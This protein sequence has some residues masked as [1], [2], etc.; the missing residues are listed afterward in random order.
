M[1]VVRILEDVCLDTR[2]S[3][4]RRFRQSSWRVSLPARTLLA[5]SLLSDNLLLGSL[6]GTNTLRR[7]TKQHV[8]KLLRR[9]TFHEHTGTASGRFVPPYLSF[10]SPGTVHVAFWSDCRTWARTL[11]ALGIHISCVLSI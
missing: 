4:S 9:S 1:C 10:R 6:L 3:Q 7:G 5:R 11:L 8:A 2:P